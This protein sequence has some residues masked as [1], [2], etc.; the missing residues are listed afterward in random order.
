MTTTPALVDPRGPRFVAGI[1]SAVLA[2]VL[3]TGSVGLLILQLAVF[4]VGAFIGPLHTPYSL[5]F[6]KL[7]A[8]RLR[9]PDGMDS[10]E[11]VRFSQALGLGFTLVGTVGYLSGAVGLG[12]VATALALF[13]AFL[14][15]AFDYCL[16][17]RV[18]PYYRRLRGRP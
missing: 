11:S 17:C 16:G 9:P 13:A 12:V 18:Y 5:L 4:A 10:I 1:T 2:L 8:P 6:R 7:V 3:I 15:A 14:N